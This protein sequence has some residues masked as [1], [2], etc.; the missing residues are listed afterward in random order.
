MSPPHHRTPQVQP[1]VIRQ[2]FFLKRPL[3]SRTSEVTEGR[4]TQKA[5]LCTQATSEFWLSKDL[6]SFQLE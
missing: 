1:C 6:H 4:C 5:D 3:C 2:T